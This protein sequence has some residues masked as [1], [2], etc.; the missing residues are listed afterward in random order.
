LKALLSPR[1]RTNDE[2]RASDKAVGSWLYRTNTV[3]LGFGVSDAP[4]RIDD[5]VEVAYSC[6]ADR[7]LERPA[8]AIVR[9]AD[10]RWAAILHDEPTDD[11]PILHRVV[12]AATREDVEMFGLADETWAQLDGAPAWIP[13]WPRRIPYQI[14]DGV[15]DAPVAGR[16]VVE[17]LASE[18]A[19]DHTIA[20][21][22]LRDGRWAVLSYFAGNA[23]NAPV[24]AV[25]V[26]ATRKRAWWFG[27]GDDDRERLARSLSPDALDE[28]LVEIDELL[29]SED[30]KE[31][32]LGER[33]ME[34]RAKDRR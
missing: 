32:A 6:P 7:E 29:E 10:D 23:T 4:V 13:R 12:V 34:R 18:Y 16:D 27:L 2:P 26:A 31:R 9:L 25:V 1:R 17:V 30:P 15:S 21:V 14:F 33:R 8:C 5:V 20:I 22:R 3:A 24:W 11:G 19:E 28:E